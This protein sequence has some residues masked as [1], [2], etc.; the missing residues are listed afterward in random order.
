MLG[1]GDYYYWWS[2]P[3]SRL[4]WIF[5]LFLGLFFFLMAAFRRSGPIVQGIVICPKCMNSFYEK[6]TENMVCPKC[7]GVLE[8]I[9]GFYE[10]HPELKNE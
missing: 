9:K 2:L 7:K 4:T 6:D 3:V 10:R 5:F 1:E 8:N